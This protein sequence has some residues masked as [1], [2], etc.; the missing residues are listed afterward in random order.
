MSATLPRSFRETKLVTNTRDI[1]DEDEA[2]KRKDLVSTKSPKELAQFH[3]LSDIP[4]PS[5][6]GDLFKHKP[7]VK[8]SK[9]ESLLRRSNMSTPT[10]MTLS[11]VT[12]S[13]VMTQTLLT[14][15]KVE[16]DSEELQKRRAVVH[17][18]SPSQLAQIHSL[19]DIPIPTTLDRLIKKD[20]YSTRKTPRDDL[21]S[22][23]EG[24][25]EKNATKS[26]LKSKMSRS[27]SNLSPGTWKPKALNSECLVRSK[28]ESPEIQS[29]RAELVNSKTVAELS[30]I[31][32]F[33][34]I[35]IPSKIQYLFEPKRGQLANDNNTMPRK[36][37]ES[38][39]PDS[40]KKEV[41][42]AQK[43]GQDQDVVKARQ[44]LV[45]SKSPTELS[46]IHSLGD[47]PVP[48]M[49]RSRPTSPSGRSVDSDAASATNFGDAKSAIYGTLRR[50]LLVKTKI[51][52]PDVQQ[53]RAETVKS[54]SVHELSQINS[55]NEIPLP[56]S[57]EG[58]VR[59]GS[60]PVERRKR[61]REK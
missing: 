39:I 44:E 30:Q 54:K 23:N 59:T 1:L 16:A 21:T 13:S 38:Y 48:R 33:S 7:G 34:D 28:I 61:F 17:S 43:S 52:D 46:E 41:L 14:K 3:G 22:L 20:K 15:S 56:A 4:V 11:R 57:V 55:L 19:G 32:S 6:I 10:P 36:K 9:S 47:F 40:L 29:A 24:D 35:P 58:W 37:I 18:M 26:Q 31:G 51:E 5:K 42:V 25:D 45:R 2:N 8:R 50:E 49:P 60:R 12:N 53:E 27:W